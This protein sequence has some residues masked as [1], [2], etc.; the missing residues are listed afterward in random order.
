MPLTFVFGFWL[1]RAFFV[2]GVWVLAFCHWRFVPRSKLKAKIIFDHGITHYT[3]QLCVW[4]KSL[5]AVEFLWGKYGHKQQE[6]HSLDIGLT[7][8][9]LRELFLLILRQVLMLL[10]KVCHENNVHTS[11]CPILTLHFL[12]SLSLG[13]KYSL[14]YYNTYPLYC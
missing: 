6:S 11:E 1:K 5:F 13:M 10:I 9:R 8:L 3:Y 4:T 14:L 2:L 7:I 12:S